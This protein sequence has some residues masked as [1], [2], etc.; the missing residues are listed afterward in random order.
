MIQAN[1]RAP[2]SIFI[3]CSRSFKFVALS[4]LFY[5]EK[6]PEVQFLAEH[7]PKGA[8]DCLAALKAKKCK[9]SREAR[10]RRG[11]TAAV[12]GDWLDHGKSSRSL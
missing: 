4:G 2:S 8:A 1:A 10:G 7:G 5:N 6:P 11:S 3:K 9:F 12:E